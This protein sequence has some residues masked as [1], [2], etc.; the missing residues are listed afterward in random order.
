MLLP[1]SSHHLFLLSPKAGLHT[2]WLEKVYI[3][4]TLKYK[5]SILL[6]LYL[7]VHIINKTNLIEKYNDA[8]ER[9]PVLVLLL[10]S[11][12]GKSLYNY[13]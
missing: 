10:H 4:K 7:R 1:A 12:P 3:L 11:T 5:V 2:R 6:P 9:L 8:G 13:W